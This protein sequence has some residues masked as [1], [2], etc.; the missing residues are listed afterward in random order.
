[1]DGGQYPQMRIETE[2][3]KNDIVVESGNNFVLNQNVF[4][5]ENNKI[6]NISS[7]NEPIKK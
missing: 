3:N 6:K 5:F 1:M 2:K 7:T 4:V